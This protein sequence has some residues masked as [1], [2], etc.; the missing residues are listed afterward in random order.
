M[1]NIIDAATGSA[2][3]L[4]VV[5]NAALDLAFVCVLV[6]ATILVSRLLEELAMWLIALFAGSGSANLIEGYLTYPGVAWH[7]FSHALFATITGAKVT[8]ISLRRRPA[9]DGKGYILGSVLYVPRGPRAL[10]SL[11]MFLTGIAPA[12][13]GLAG[14][15]A[16]ALLAFPN[17]TEIWQWIIWI[18][19]FICL[20]LHSGPSGQD[21]KGVGA[22][23]PLVALV[24]FVVFLLLPFDAPALVEDAFSNVQTAVAAL[25]STLVP[26][27]AL[28]KTL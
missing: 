17:C 4:S 25:T 23:A 27:E 22:G 18:Y 19:L 6:L 24:L 5:Q 2:T 7:E 1:P 11:Q 12:I 13:T 16:I 20:L 14:M 15:A 9:P 3:L 8:S 10:Q 21:L 26:N 28:A